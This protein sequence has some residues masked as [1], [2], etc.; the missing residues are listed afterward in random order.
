MH[1]IHNDTQRKTAGLCVF[2]GSIIRIFIFFVSEI[3]SH[4]ARQLFFLAKQLAKHTVSVSGQQKFIRSS[5]RASHTCKKNLK[6]LPL[7]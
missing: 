1:K 4:L 2:S 3:F 6:A 5:P 7:I